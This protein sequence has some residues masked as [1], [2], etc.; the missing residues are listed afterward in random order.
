MVEERETL[1]E[2]CARVCA[3]RDKLAS[4]LHQR[5]IHPDYEYITTTGPR[6]AWYDAPDLTKE[7]WGINTDLGHDG[8]ERFDY[9]EEQY[10]RRKRLTIVEEE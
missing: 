10:W 2:A 6:K 8:W 7:G 5:R 9:H 3:E 1:D 4:A